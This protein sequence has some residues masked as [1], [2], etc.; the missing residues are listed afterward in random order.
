MRHRLGENPQLRNATD[1]VNP[2][3][4]FNQIRTSAYKAAF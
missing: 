1:L 4:I 3:R 2:D